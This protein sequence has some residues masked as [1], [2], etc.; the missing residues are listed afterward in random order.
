MTD[1]LPGRKGE[2]RAEPCPKVVRIDPSSNQYTR[3]LGGPPETATMRS[4]SVVLLPG[5]SVG[6]HTTGDYEEAIVVLEGSGELLISGGADLELGGNSV[7]YC[8]PA[9][10][11]DI[12]N[13]G[14][15]PLRYVY[16]VARAR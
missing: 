5:Q 1:A 4:G 6:K 14:T 8:A 12:V 9:T 11:H 10:E 2:S 16:V 3:L 15:I 7:A 13:T